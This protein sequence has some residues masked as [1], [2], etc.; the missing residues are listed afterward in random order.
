MFDDLLNGWKATVSGAL[1]DVALGWG[2]RQSLRSRAVPLAGAGLLL[3]ATLGYGYW[4]LAGSDLRQGPIVITRSR[5]RRMS[6]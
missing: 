4:R 1:A 3:L 6:R 5:E 2:K